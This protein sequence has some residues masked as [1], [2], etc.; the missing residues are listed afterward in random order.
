[1]NSKNEWS[2]LKKVIVG[3][4]NNAKI[5]KIDLSMRTINYADKKDGHLKIVNVFQIILEI[6]KLR[7]L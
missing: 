3:I 2:Q 5:P 7:K 1:M 4:A 6:N